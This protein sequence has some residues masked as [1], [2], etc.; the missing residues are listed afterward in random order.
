MSSKSVCVVDCG[1]GSTRF[2][3]YSVHTAG[4]GYVHE[5]RYQPS[6]V[7]PTLVSALSG[8]LAAI[9]RWVA[10]L[11]S[12]VDDD[13]E[14]GMPVIVG[15]TAG[16]RTALD[17]GIISDAQIKEFEQALAEHFG[18]CASFRL[19]TGE[20]EAECELFAVRYIARHALPT[21]RPKFGGGTK[22]ID[23]VGMLSC[24]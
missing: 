2:S 21:V 8:G 7:L 18:D 24:G 17:E 22:P 23:D 19:L 5:D 20:E 15:A 4:D 1:S 13:G 3:Q 6:G 11:K 9:Q 12:I 10:L 14:N 16:V